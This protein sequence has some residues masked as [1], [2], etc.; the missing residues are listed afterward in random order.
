MFIEKK[1]KQNV[2]NETTPLCQPADL[3]T[4]PIFDEI[5]S[6]HLVQKLTVAAEKSAQRSSKAKY[7]ALQF[8]EKAEKCMDSFDYELASKFCQRAVDLEADNVPALEMLGFLRL[9]DENLDSAR[10]VSFFR[11]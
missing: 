5:C 11:K 9:Q 4:E 7:S 10:K 1:Q 6:S 2:E 8:L 3:S